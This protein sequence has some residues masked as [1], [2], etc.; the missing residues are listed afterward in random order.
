MAALGCGGLLVYSGLVG[1]NTATPE[2]KTISAAVSDYISPYGTT[3]RV[4]SGGS[5]FW[6][7]GK[8]P[9]TIFMLGD[10]NMEQYYP[11]VLA[12]LES[13]QARNS[14]LFAIHG[15]CPPIPHVSSPQHLFCPGFMQDAFNYA[16]EHSEIQTIVVAAQW[17]SYFESPIYKID[18][19]G[20]SF[21]LNS[22]QGNQAA[23][24]LLAKE[25]HRLRRAGKSIYLVLNIPVGPSYAPLAR[26]HRTSWGTPN[27]TPPPKPQLKDFLSHYSDVRDRLIEL[28]R[29]LNIQVID[30]LDYLCHAGTCPAADTDGIPRYKDASHL[31]AA[32][33]RERVSYLDQIFA[34]PKIGDLPAHD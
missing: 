28:G 33:V 11:R 9:Q 8:G 27:V 21:P 23:L 29:E 22:K 3:T 6:R 30:P 20:Q 26:V 14:V 25:L 18:A 19:D 17:S 31:R 32:F 5:D 15:G 10:S 4:R 7:V 13:G 2:M 1:S 24:Q 16:L 12:L 34:A